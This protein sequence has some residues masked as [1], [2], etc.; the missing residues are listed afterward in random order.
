MNTERIKE[1]ASE[2]QDKRAEKADLENKVKQLKA[3]IKDIEEGSLNSL[4]Q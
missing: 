3:E 4:L 2:L 1:L